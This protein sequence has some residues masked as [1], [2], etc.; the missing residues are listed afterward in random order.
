MKTWKIKPKD[1]KVSQFIQCYWFL[2][3]ELGDISNN[4][5]KLNPDP[6]ATFVIAPTQ[7]SYSYK[8]KRMTFDGQGC[9]WIFPNS[10]TMQ[11]DHSQ[12][13]SIIGIKFHIGALYSLN[14]ALESSMLK[15]LEDENAIKRPIIDYVS[16]VDCK[17][18]IG[19]TGNQTEL[20]SLA[21]TN[22][23]ECA[24]KLDKILYQRLQYCEQ[25]KQSQ[26]THQAAELLST[27]AV[28]QMGK[29]L[30]CSQRTIERNFSL[31]TGFT[32]KQCQSMNRFEAILNR[33]H[34][35]EAQDVNWLDIVAEFG[36]SDQPHLIRY[37]KS[38]VGQTPSE[39]IKQRDITIDIYGN[40]EPLD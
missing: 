35:I 22:P 29:M 20:L 8:N 12:P 23:E 6:T 27:T 25:D 26:L 7:Q 16:Q 24:S 33:L 2:E 17:T 37:L 14:V 21:K 5:P 34:K 31:V 18:F 32:L 15:S 38:F 10:Q 36:F 9:H 1:P 3:K 28:Q 30:N 4:Y 40:F 13:F 11:L 39:Y 19:E